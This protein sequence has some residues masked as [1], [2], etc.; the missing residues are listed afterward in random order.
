MSPRSRGRSVDMVVKCIVMMIG[1]VL[2]ACTLN[3]SSAA[4]IAQQEDPTPVVTAQQVVAPT[5]S[6]RAIPDNVI[7]L[8]DAVVDN[9][10]QIY[11]RGQDMGNRATVFSKVGDSITVNANFL[12]PFGDELYDL[13]EY[14]YL[15]A[16]VD[17][18]N[19]SIARR[20]N[21]F[22]NRSIAAAQGWAAW[23][24]LTPEL[25][26]EPDCQFYERPLVCE[27]RVVQPSFA[28]IMFGTNDVGY[29]TVEQYRADMAQIIDISIQNGVVPILTTMPPQPAQIGRVELFND[30]LYVLAEDYAVPV[31]DYYSAMLPLPNYGLAWDNVHPSSPPDGYEA[32]GFLSSAN[33]RYGY[34]MRNL[35]TLQML[36]SVVRYAISSG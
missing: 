13:G 21:S 29:R 11:R 15:Q 23:G 26:N 14:A 6:R 33:L 34:V 3:A 35:L 24:A 2:S 18:F 25:Q 17:Y 27:Y 8:P 19:Q 9:I 10:Q 22:Y 30:T 7:P 20:S 31:I 16:I 1:L 36:D 4:V 32:A 28:V 5:A 12:A